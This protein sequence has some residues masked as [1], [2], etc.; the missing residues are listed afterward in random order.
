MSRT[1]NILPEVVASKIAAGEVIQRP[2]SVVKELLENSLDAGA[3]SI[4]VI[5]AESGK[6]LIQVIDNGCG[7]NAEDAAIAF[8]RHAT[9]KIKSAEDLEEIH[10]FGFRGE[11]LATIAAVSQVEMK[12]RQS[13]VEVGTR[14]RIEGGL[15]LEI[16]E[17]AAPV[18][19]SVRAKNLFYNTPARRKF[20]KSDNTEFKHIADAVQRVAVAYPEIAIEFISDDETIFNLKASSPEERMREVFGENLSKTVFYFNDETATT[21]LAGFL[22]KPDFARKGRTE[23]YLYLNR[24]YIQSRS[25]NH[26]VFQAYENLLEKGSFPFF[27]LFLSLDPRKVDVNVHPS[28]M[29]VKF[30]DEQSMYRFVLSSVRRALSEHD[31]I[32][33]V[34]MQKG[35]HDILHSGLRFTQTQDVSQQRV[36]S[37]EELLKGI[38][39]QDET[40]FRFESEPQPPSGAGVENRFIEKPS[41]I[42][43]GEATVVEQGGSSTLQPETHDLGGSSRPNSIQLDDN[44]QLWQLHRKY[45]IIPVENGIMLVDQ[46]AAHERVMYERI[47]KRMEAGQIVSQQ[48]LFSQTIELPASDVAFVK[49]LHSLLEQLGFSI[50]F[51]GRTTIVI[52]GVP[53]DVKSGNEAT[54][55]QNVLD[56][57]KEDEQTVKLA[58]RERLAKTFACKAAIKAGD[59]LTEIEMRA[60]LEQLFATQIPT[61]C[62]HGRPTMIRMTLED[63]DR[64]FGRTPMGSC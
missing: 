30:E 50:K 21:A 52:D 45:I 49:E 11:A 17:D 6:S 51:F 62:P 40:K 47:I 8:E 55:L 7:M 28:K 42:E 5:I 46:H 27:V 4:T 3:T 59:P 37:W 39:K 54:I 32:P 15:L 31:L 1:I 12:T 18:G 14:A 35:A 26:A 41:P 44:I 48:L 13:T 60:I 58:P 2:A 23:Q 36:S 61:V 53:G 24:R 57:Y 34:G 25:L 10:T 9:S 64:R 38:P 56:V 33:S 20:L 19:T 29:E 22:G 63:L 43:T 16:V